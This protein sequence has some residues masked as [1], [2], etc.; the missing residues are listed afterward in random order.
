MF[1]QVL[2]IK[3]GNLNPM[4]GGRGLKKQS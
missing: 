3:I 2:E 1:I 4:Q